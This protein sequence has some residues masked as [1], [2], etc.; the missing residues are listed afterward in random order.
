MI[1]YIIT[2][3]FQAPWNIG[4]TKA[5][6][7]CIEKGT[8]VEIATKYYECGKGISWGKYILD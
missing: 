6:R 8:I 5:W 1:P 4:P 3:E 7:E 2:T